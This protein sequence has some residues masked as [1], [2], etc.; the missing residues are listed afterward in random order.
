MILAA[1][2]L[3]DAS[4]HQLSTVLQSL[5]MSHSL[6]GG[7]K[8]TLHMTVNGLCKEQ[9][10]WPIVVDRV[11][12]V[13][14]VRVDM[15]RAVYFVCDARAAL[16]TSNTSQV[17]W[18][19]HR[20]LMDITAAVKQA[21]IAANSL[22][23][24]W[25]FVVNEPTIEDYVNIATKPSFFNHVQSAMYRITPYN[26]RKEV[27]LMCVAYLAGSVSVTA[28][29]RKLKSSHKLEQLLGLMDSQKARDLRDAVAQARRENV[30][31]VARDTGFEQFEILYVLRSFEKS[32]G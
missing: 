27:N 22:T 32:K 12:S 18:P 21:L 8:R 31:I 10:V 14:K 20:G 23:H 30:E 11:R 13:P 19:E 24:D 3:V 17:L 7:S 4:P 9:P 5:K 6:V 25:Q 26:L 16:S 1:Y 28:L 15:D 2:G 29:K